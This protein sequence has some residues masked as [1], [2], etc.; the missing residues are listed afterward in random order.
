LNTPLFRCLREEL[1][2]SE[3]NAILIAPTLST[4]FGSNSPSRYG[5]LNEEV[6]EH[7]R[8]AEGAIIVGAARTSVMSNF[9]M[10]TIIIAALTALALFLLVGLTRINSSEVVD[11]KYRGLINLSA[12]K[13]QSTERSSFINRVCYNAV[14]SYM[15]VQIKRRPSQFRHRARP[16]RPRET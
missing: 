15:I 13:C 10:V 14:K 12:F 7:D 9:R 4:V 3:T 2:A 11:V 1:D 8:L 16:R 5:N 6:W